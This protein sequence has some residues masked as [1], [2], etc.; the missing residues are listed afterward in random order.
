MQFPKQELDVDKYFENILRLLNDT[1]CHIFID[2]NIISQLYRL[3]DDAR[4]DFYKWVDFCGD[5]FHI[6]NWSVH[7]YSKRINTQNTKDYL[8]ELSKAKTIAKEM[9]NIKNFIKGYVGDS[10]LEGSEYANNRGTLFND[11]DLVT[12]KFEKIAN[13][14]NKNLSNHQQKVHK[15]VLEKLNDYTLDSDI[16]KIIS[17]L[18]SEHELRFDGKIPPGYKDSE[19]SSN[20]IGDL[21]IW[22]EIIEF[23]NSRD[24][25]GERA[26]AIFV[27][28]DLKPDMVYMPPIQKRNNNKLNKDE[29]KINIAQES[30]VYEFKLETESEDFYL[31][32]FYTLVQI[33]ASQYR[34]LAV[35]FQIATEQEN[36]QLIDEEI[37][38]DKNDEVSIIELCSENNKTQEDINELE[39][40][41]IT[42]PQNKSSISETRY[43]KAAIEDI[44]YDTSEGNTLVNDCIN[45][46][47]TYNWYVQ[48]PAIDSLN[49]LIFK[50]ISNIDQNR[51]SFFVLG[52]NILQSADGSSG[53]AISFLENLHTSI[54][55]WPKNFQ[56]AFIDGCLYEVFFDSYGKIRSKAFKS[57]YLNIVVEEALKIDSN[58]SFEFINRELENKNGGRFVPKVN[59]DK[60]YIFEFN[61]RISEFYG[62]ETEKLKIDGKDVS[63]TFKNYYHHVFCYA[64]EI[65][66]KLSLY[67]GIPT[68]YIDLGTLP[69][70]LKIVYYISE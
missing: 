64:E 40:V 37:N 65:N 51:D 24:Y 59:S 41:V 54:K 50:S 17:N 20:S 31:I 60:K 66:I 36:I 47:K 9:N 30:L 46:L 34:Q 27:S 63:D 53:S 39:Q 38:F 5:R 7:E 12:N 33:L 43:S 55:S 22:K 62:Y 25:K 16:Y 11:I 15:E 10:L 56:I 28:R 3:N 44:Y 61:F 48:N 13:A 1:S 52:R 42:I 23:Y 14:I 68:K 49:N 8:A 19:K 26:K 45:N 18:Y 32:S 21:I 2:T 69:D 67:Y 57:S 29:D 35:S 58:F 70:D 6:P 4:Q